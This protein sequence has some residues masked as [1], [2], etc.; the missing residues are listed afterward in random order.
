MTVKWS[1]L[2]G[3]FPLYDEEEDTLV[4]QSIIGDCQLCEYRVKLA[5]QEGYLQAIS[6][7]LVFGTCTHHLIAQDLLVGEP[8]LDLLT[9]MDEWVEEILVT[10]YDWSLSQVPNPRDFFAEVTTA[11][12]QWRKSVYPKL[13]EA[14]ALEKEMYMYLGEGDKGNYHLRGT[15]DA[16]FENQIMDWKTSGRPWKD[17]KA[18]YSI[19][20]SLYMGLVKQDTGIPIRKFVFWIFNKSKREWQAIRTERR[21]K[22]INAAL[23]SAYDYAR[24]IEAGVYTATPVREVFS[25]KE[26]GWYCSAKY[27]GA[28][29]ICPVKYLNDDVDENVLAIRSW[30]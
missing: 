20:A 18:H 11:Y 8:R 10:E 4:R 2:P 25:K 30:S 26:R 19:Q 7:P 21:V 6:E 13:P 24:K 27:C 23:V 28:W 29:N 12:R 9:S 5:T 1:E 22:E 17:G 15:P 16:V 3:T 14:I